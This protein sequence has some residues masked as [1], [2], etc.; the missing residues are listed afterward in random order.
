[1][2]VT[3]YV[4]FGISPADCRGPT[5]TRPLEN[6]LKRNYRKDAPQQSNAG[7]AVVRIIRDPEPRMVV[8]VVFPDGRVSSDWNDFL[9][10]RG[11]SQDALESD[12]HPVRVEPVPA[13]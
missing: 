1:M 11:L 5:S 4:V 3:R 7:T 12:V 10:A 2:E 6:Q 8:E 9:R 13:A